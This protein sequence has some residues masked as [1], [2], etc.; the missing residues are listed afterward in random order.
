[1]SFNMDTLLIV[2]VLLVYMVVRQFTEQRVNVINLVLL[3]VLSGYLS[4]TELQPDFAHFTALPLLAGLAIGVLAGLASGIFRG[5]NTRV[6]LD[7]TSGQIYAKPLLACSLMW[8]VLLLVRISVIALN[9]SPLGHSLLAGV[10]L[11]C[12][13]ALF[14]VSIST[15]KVMVF[16]QYSRLQAGLAR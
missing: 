10:L 11:A 14:V 13:G 5:R 12:A 4:Y 8:I 2:A 16:A 15:Q 6:R 3:P 1:M 9:Y 7:S